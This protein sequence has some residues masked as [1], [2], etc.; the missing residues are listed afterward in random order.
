MKPRQVSI[1]FVSTSHLEINSLVNYRLTVLFLLIQYLS[2]AVGTTHHTHAR[3]S[4][5]IP[6]LLD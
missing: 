1:S 4:C 3:I 2:P 5:R 6:A